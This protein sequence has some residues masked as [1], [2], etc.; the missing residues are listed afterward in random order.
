[1]IA[2]AATVALTLLAAVAAG[3]RD[4][5]AGDIGHAAVWLVLAAVALVVVVTPERTGD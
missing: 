4:L 1:M 2:V 3:V 5:A